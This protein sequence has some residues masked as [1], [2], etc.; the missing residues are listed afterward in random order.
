MEA[1]NEMIKK[2]GKELGIKVTISQDNWL[3][4]L[5]KDNKTRYITGYQF[6]LNYHAI[7]N[8]M[9][10]K[11][12][13]YELLRYKKIPVISQ[14]IIFKDYDKEQVLKYFYEHNQ[15]IIVKGNISN[16]GKEVFKVSREQELFR[17]I[18]KLFLKQFSISLCPYYHIINEYRII[19]LDNVIRT[20]FGKEKPKVVGDGK[21]TIKELAIKEYDYYILHEDEITNASYI[22]KKDEVVELSFK[23]NLSAG[24]KSFSNIN[25]DLKT[26]LEDLAF[27]VTNNLNISF[28]S[29]DII[30]TEKDEL[31]VLEANSGVTMNKY[32]LQ[33]KDGYEIAYNIYRDAI[34]LMFK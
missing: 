17:V 23:F 18:D 6:D 11:G 2:I 12:L 19:V 22:P 8:I 4:I 9:D 31:L 16:A 20:I 34:K 28:A 1:F 29:V 7:G 5:E 32:I 25:E 10:D 33:N 14:Y 26:K 13:F 27:L 30:H 15:E 3:K 21:K 24:A